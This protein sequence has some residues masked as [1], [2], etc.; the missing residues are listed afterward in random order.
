METGSLL[1]GSQG[2]SPAAEVNGAGFMVEISSLLGNVPPGICVDS[3]FILLVI[4]C[5]T[6]SLLDGLPGVLPTQVT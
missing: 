2:F 4:D 3:V 6:G 1:D 5:E